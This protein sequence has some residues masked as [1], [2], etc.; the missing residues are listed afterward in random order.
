MKMSNQ[1]KPTPP[2][3]VIAPDVRRKWLTAGKKYKVV[4]IWGDWDE[5]FGYGFYIIDDNG[6]IRH[7][8]EYGSAHLYNLNWI[9][10]ERE[11]SND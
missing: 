6:K 2:K 1:T 11:V 3:V 5:V 4:G 10:A 7:T 9:I 8:V